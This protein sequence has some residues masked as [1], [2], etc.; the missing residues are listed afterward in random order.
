MPLKMDIT[1]SYTKVASD[2]ALLKRIGEFIRYHRLEQNYTQ[3]QLSDRAGINRGTLVELEKGGRSNLLT[4]IQVLRMLD[5]LH[6]LN[7]FEIDNS[8]TP[9]QL[10][11]MSLKYRK[12]ASGKK[13]NPPKSDW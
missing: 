8:P 10:A 1:N 11:E 4:L 5:L 6:A 3:Q 13:K 9:M 2:D 7:T 12:R